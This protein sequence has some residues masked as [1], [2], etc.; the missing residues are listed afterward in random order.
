MLLDRVLSAKS[1]N[2]SDLLSLINKFQPIIKK[3]GVKLDG[4]DG[5]SE[6][7][8]FLI[9][10]IQNFQSEKL[11]NC[12]DGTLI[13]YFYTCI[14]REFLRLFTKRQQECDLLVSDSTELDYY[15][16]NQE[17]ITNGDPVGWYISA[18]SLTHNE[19][20][21]IRLIFE[22]GYSSAEI[23]RQFGVTRQ[24]INQIKRRALTKIKQGLLENQKD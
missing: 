24:N 11:I 7:T 13:N 23:A 15:I 21:I 3:Y 19:E 12:Y 8:V 14:Y 17:S 10:L 9:E 5:K 6:L 18:G 1:G 4:E 2:Q 20:L 22:R 16:H